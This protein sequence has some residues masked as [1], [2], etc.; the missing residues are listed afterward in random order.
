VLWD[1]ITVMAPPI[2]L[3]HFDNRKPGN[4]SALR[5]LAARGGKRS[6]FGGCFK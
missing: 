5:L 4:R 1:A 2:V 3:T 6:R